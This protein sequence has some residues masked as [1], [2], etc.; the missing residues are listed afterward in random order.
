MYKKRSRKNLYFALILI[1]ILAVS[2]AAIVYATQFSKPAAVP[3]GVHVGDTFTYKLTGE[4][5]LGSVDAVT[6]A[7]LSA[8]NDTD[9]YQITITGIVASNVSFN[10]VWRFTNGTEITTPQIMDIA[11]GNKSDASGF[12]AIYPANLKVSDLLRPTGFDGIK[13]NA[14]ESQAYGATNRTR[15]FWQIE[16]QFQDTNDPT[17]N[18]MRDDYIGVY[19]DQHT[20]MLTT[21][22]NVQRYNNPQYNIIITWQLTSSNV[23]AVQ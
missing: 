17:G 8:Y 1:V 7:Y 22:T 4:S 20:G 19:F 16:N 13:V 12:W 21:L 3:V 5:V 10:T 23:W 15:D 14:T 6:P 2:V 18:T 11:S 9:Y